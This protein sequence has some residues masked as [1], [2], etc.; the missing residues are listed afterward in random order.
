MSSTKLS[1]RTRLVGGSVVSI[2]IVL[3][4][5]SGFLRAFMQ[6]DSTV[7]E[8]KQVEITRSEKIGSLLRELSNVHRILSETLTGATH[9][10]I[11]EEGIFDK[12]R[13]VIDS[14]RAAT[15]EFSASRVFFGNDQ[16]F[17]VLFDAAVKDMKNYRSTVVSVVEMATA[18]A[19]LASAEML[20]ASLS[21]ARLVDSLGKIVKLNN[22]KITE[23]LDGTLAN[24]RFIYQYMLASGIAALLALAAISIFLYRD[25]SRSIRAIIDVLADLGD[26]K[27]RTVV[28]SQERADEIGAIARAIELFRGREI[29]RRRLISEGDMRRNEEKK[30]A[31]AVAYMIEKFRETVA[32]TLVAA[33]DTIMRMQLTSED[34]KSIVA[35]A[36]QRSLEAAASTEAMSSNVQLVATAA[37][38][39]RNSF[40]DIDSQASRAGQ[41]VER[42]SAATKTADSLVNKLAGNAA[43]IDEVSRVIANVTSQVNLLALNATIE[44]ARAGEFGRGFAVVASEVKALAAQTSNS[45]TQIA[46]QISDIQNLTVNAVQSVRSIGEAVEDVA[47]STHAIAGT[48]EK[49]SCTTNEIA[50]TCQKA[51]AGVTA[52]ADNIAVVKQAIAKTDRSAA[53]VF[54]ASTALSSHTRTLQDAINGFLVAVAAA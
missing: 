33:S 22:D 16:S 43:R 29:E 37:D 52:L 13:S 7:Q 4:I 3:V 38:A 8:I 2:F 10:Q 21:Y 42:V 32:E 6:Q 40:V 39:L 36:N 30:R 41:F 49:Q 17:L 34:L 15:Q 27:V 19:Q 48:L 24:S 54:D 20:K 28:P 26:G 18:D 5:C 12:G 47:G 46:A 23:S 51:N 31:E 45:N 53:A 9:R 14:V 11:D 50:Q 1:L 35:E 44:A 25:I